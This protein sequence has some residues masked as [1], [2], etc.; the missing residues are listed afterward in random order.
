MLS[1]GIS[2]GRV[3][4]QRGSLASGGQ[5]LPGAV[6]TRVPVSS[7]L[8]VSGFC[9]VKVPVM[10]TVPPTGMSPVQVIAVAVR[11]RLPLVATWSPVGVASS[12][13]PLVGLVTVMPV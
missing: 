1:W 7:L 13:T 8:P 3:A 10:V 5:L 2:T 12:T 11:L 9:T 4:V 6:E